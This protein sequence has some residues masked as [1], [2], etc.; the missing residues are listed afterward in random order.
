MEGVC[1]ALVQ[2]PGA[3]Q[4]VPGSSPPQPPLE[5]AASSVGPHLQES[6][7]EGPSYHGTEWRER[8]QLLEQLQHAKITAEGPGIM[9]SEERF[10][11]DTC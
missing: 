6:P 3:P 9:R 5:V 11:P 4:V 2:L 7:T 10:I 8:R 1:P